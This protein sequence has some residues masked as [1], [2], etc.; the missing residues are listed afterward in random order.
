MS[1]S[2]PDFATTTELLRSLIRIPSFSKKENQTADTLEA[3]FDGRNLSIQRIGHNVIVKPTNWR[4]GLPVCLLNSHHDTVRPAAGYQRDPFDAAMAGDIIYGLG[5]NDAGGCLVAMTHV[6]CSLAQRNDLPVNLLFVASAEE[7]ISGPGGIRMVLPTLPHVDFA[8]VG[9][10]TQM[11]MGVAEKGLVVIDAL[12]R[13]QSGH[14]ARDEGINAL[15]LALDDIQRLRQYRFAESSPLLGDCRAT[16]TQLDAGSQ[17]NVV[18][19]VCRY[20]IDVRTNE[21]YTNAEVVALL[22]ALLTAELTPRSLRLNSSGIAAHHPLVRAGQRI[23]L[24]TYGSPTLSDMALL[25]F[26]AV[27]IGPGLSARSH[28]ADEFIRLSEIQQGIECY[29]KLLLNIQ[30]P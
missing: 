26:P 1:H 3:Y 27:K 6:F 23:G 9:E 28:T 8:I 17:H 18:P 13:G 2:P 15:Y 21:R 30:H 19:D 7:E 25:P 20:V 4:T 5:S 22:E 12:C 29:E 14:A 16:V 10:P 11:R 24:A